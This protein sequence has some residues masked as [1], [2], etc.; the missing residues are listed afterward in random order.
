L[1]ED[2]SRLGGRLLYAWSKAS[3]DL[4]QGFFK[5]GVMLLKA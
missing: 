5:L 4:E 2:Y 1:E 3:Q